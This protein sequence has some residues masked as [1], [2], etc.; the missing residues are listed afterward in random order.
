MIDV[1]AY[2]RAAIKTECRIGL[3]LSVLDYAY[4][5]NFKIIYTSFR[6][7][8]RKI[9]RCVRGNGLNRKAL[10][11]LFCNLNFIESIKNN[12]YTVSINRKSLL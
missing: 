3:S 10:K 6:R 1:C 5:L 4:K 11:L 9:G 7:R 2:Y 8:N 12:I